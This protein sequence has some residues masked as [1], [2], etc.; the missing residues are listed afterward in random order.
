MQTAAS[1]LLLLFG[2][3][4]SV[5]TRFVQFRCFGA[6]VRTAFSG[7]GRDG[8]VTAFEAMATSLAA[9]I[10]T[11]NIAGVAGAILLGGPGVL[12]WM[13]VTALFGMAAKYVEIVAGLRWGR[14]RGP[15]GYL[16]R[17]PGGAALSVAYGALCALSALTMGN[18]IQVRTVTECVSSLYQAVGGSLHVPGWLSPVCGGC[19]ALAVAVSLLGGAKRVGRAAALLVPVMSVLYILG[20]LYVIC[21]NASALPE[22]LAQVWRRAWTPEAFLVGTARGVFS[23]EAGLGTAAV[24]RMSRREANPHREGLNGI[25]EVFLDTVV[26]CTLTALAILVSAVALPYGNGDVN[27]ALVIDAFRGSLG[28]VPAAVF[29]T[30]SMLLFAFSSIMSFALY[31]ELCF[32]DLFPN[33]GRRIYRILFILTVGAGASMGVSAAWRVAE[34]VNVLL[35]LVNMAGLMLLLTRQKGP[36]FQRSL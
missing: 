17:V 4:A 3:Y 14:G 8:N 26:L 20:S 34:T 19:I 27:G 36:A 10:G 25:F 15:M 21:R 6:S 33:R 5:R 13:W 35:A 9:T 28:D 31:G 7:G 32:G 12:V 11:G 16:C 18:L 29:I 24:A 23:H 30:G 1:I 2:G 22:A